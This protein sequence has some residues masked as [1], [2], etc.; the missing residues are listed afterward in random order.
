MLIL[1]YYDE[2]LKELRL[3]IREQERIES[4]L[5]DLNKQYSSLRQK[6]EE[7]KNIAKCEEKD[8]ERLNGFTFSDFFSKLRGNF[9]ARLSKEQEESYVAAVKYNMTLKELSEVESDIF[10]FDKKLREY[11]NCRTQYDDVLS[12]KYTAI[13]QSDIPQATEII[14]IE[15]ECYELELQV[16]EIAEAITAGKNSLSICDS[17]LNLLDSAENWG[18]YDLIAG[19]TFSSVVKH[20]KL[21]DA[22]AYVERLQSSLRRFKTELSDIDIDSDIKVDIDGF[23]RFADIFFDCFFADYKVLKRIQKSN[24]QVRE[25]KTKINSV[26]QK[27]STLKSQYEKKIFNNRGKINS[28]VTETVL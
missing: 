3:Q 14:T 1:G 26:I 17:V 28:L 6:A 15:K 8:V 5:K 27:L 24:G 7:L 23:L 10:N 11:R 18:T 21:D 20:S 12:Q 4:I 2:R 16:R 19:D 13:K 25:I 22:Q 9:E